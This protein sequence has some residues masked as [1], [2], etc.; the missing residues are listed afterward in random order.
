[1]IRYTRADGRILNGEHYFLLWQ[2]RIVHELAV[3]MATKIVRTSLSGVA[4]RMIASH[5]PCPEDVTSCGTSFLTGADA[6]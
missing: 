2:R 1:M 5:F 3:V 4:S 6:T